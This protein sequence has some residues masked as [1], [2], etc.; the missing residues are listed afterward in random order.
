VLGVKRFENFDRLIEVQVLQQVAQI[1]GHP[2]VQDLPQSFRVVALEKFLDLGQREFFEDR[3][4]DWLRCGD[5]GFTISTY[6]PG[7]ALY[8]RKPRTAGPSCMEKQSL[9]GTHART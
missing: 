6:F 5:D 3:H 8:W 9:R 1:F 2:M 7:P 4:G